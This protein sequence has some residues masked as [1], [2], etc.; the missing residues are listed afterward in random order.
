M[1]NAAIIGL[2]RWGRT[3]V[4]SVQ[5]K[6]DRLRFSRAVVR[7]LE[8]HRSF[9]EAAGLALTSDFEKVLVDSGIAGPDEPGVAPERGR[10]GALDF[11]AG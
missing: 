3:L 2:G 7:S 1:I 4:G 6:S 11:R 9:A 8:S 10:A 5:G